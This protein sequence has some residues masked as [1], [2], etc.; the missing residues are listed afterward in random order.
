MSVPYWLIPRYPA[1]K[2]IYLHCCISRPSAP[3][4]RATKL[5]SFAFCFPPEC[6]WQ[7]IQYPEIIM[8]L[9]LHGTLNTERCRD[10]KDYIMWYGV[11]K[12]DKNWVY[13]LRWAVQQPTGTNTKILFVPP[14]Q[15]NYW[16]IF[17]L[18]CIMSHC[19]S[20]CD[21]TCL[22]ACSCVNISQ[23]KTTFVNKI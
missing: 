7:E 11:H 6:F 21:V 20:L 8:L 3:P 1:Q 15:S 12:S 5:L 22:L 9:W 10:H 13:D 19:C 17:V 16:L 2:I 18:F 4:P 14:P 23:N